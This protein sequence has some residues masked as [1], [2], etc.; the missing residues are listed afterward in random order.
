MRPF[1]RR[2]FSLALAAVCGGVF[3][4]RSDASWYWPFGSD[5]PSQATPV[6]AAP[7]LHQATPATSASTGGKS[8]FHP[9]TWS[10]PKMPWSS[11]SSSTTASSTAKPPAAKNA[12]TKPQSANTAASPWQSVKNGTHH[13]EN[14]TAS[15]WHKTVHAVTPGSDEP[16]Q[17]VAAQT[18]KN[19]WWNRMWGSSAEEQKPDGPRTVGE[20]MAQKRLEP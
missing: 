13:V 7:P 16:K 4:T 1:T 5:Q 9:S 17:Q 14:A 8:V 11:D 6:S 10:T 12:W 19:S 3:V 18:P 2:M 20:F 15:A